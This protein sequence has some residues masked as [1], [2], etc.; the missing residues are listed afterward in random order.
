MEA[1]MGKKIFVSYKY[2]DTSAKSLKEQLEEFYNPTK[3]R[4]YVDVI[5]EKIGAEH[6]NKGE[7]DGEDLSSFKESTIASKLRDKIFDSSVTII[8]ISPNMVDRT[9]PESDQ[10]IPWEISYSLREQ[11]RADRT[12]RTNGILSIVLPDR[13]G[14]YNY[15]LEPSN[16]PCC[17]AI[18]FQTQKV[19]NIIGGNMFNHKKK[20]EQIIACSNHSTTIYPANCSYILTTDWE[21]FLRNPNL[22]IDSAAERNINEYNVQKT[23]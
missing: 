14:S 20:H 8:L 10:W 16:C 6:V 2:G 17:N 23:V 22:W 1:D 15:Y 19:F 21:T 12:S 3:V 4:D 7:K 11:T 5:Q 18:I 9:L 13:Y